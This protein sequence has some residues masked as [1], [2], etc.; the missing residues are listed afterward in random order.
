ML[1]RGGDSKCVIITWEQQ[2]NCSLRAVLN[3]RSVAK[4]FNMNNFIQ[5]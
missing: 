4:S 3:S 2:V 1:P 5:Q